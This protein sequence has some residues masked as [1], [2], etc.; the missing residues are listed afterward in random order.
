MQSKGTKKRIPDIARELRVGAVV[1][2]SVERS[3]DR[4]RVRVQLIDAATDQHLWAESYDRQMSD[5]LQLE[6]DIARDIAQQI[7]FHVSPQQQQT[8]AQVRVTNPQA[9]QDYLQSRQYW[10]TRSEEGLHKAV[11]FFNRAIA[12]DPGDAR[13]YAGLAHCYVV[14]PLLYNVSYNVAYAK[15]TSRRQA[16]ARARSLAR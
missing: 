13:S 11:D 6:A 7:Q 10:A 15:G 1:E 16:S 8:L 4:M 3:A 2:G 5:V 12:E 9:F 14:F